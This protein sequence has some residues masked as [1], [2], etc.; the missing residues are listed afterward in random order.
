LGACTDGSVRGDCGGTHDDPEQL[1]SQVASLSVHEDSAVVSVVD[2]GELSPHSSF[3]KEQEDMKE[4]SSQCLGSICN[5]PVQ[6]SLSACFA[7]M[8]SPSSEEPSDTM[9]VAQ[10][11]LS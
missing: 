5:Y 11:I 6:C 3:I 7:T 9:I 1:S 8:D 2:A 10:L 4:L